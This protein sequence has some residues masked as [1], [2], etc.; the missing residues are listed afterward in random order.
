V[1]TLNRDWDALKLT[2]FDDPKLQKKEV[3]DFTQYPPRSAGSTESARRVSPVC[4]KLPSP[5]HSHGGPCTVQC[6]SQPWSKPL[7][8]P[9]T[10]RRE[11]MVS[12]RL[13][14]PIKPTGFLATAGTPAATKARATRS[15]S[16]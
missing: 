12:Y 2:K 13:G 10:K 1:K 14:V 16:T 5:P 7:S 4:D 6:S 3:S 8:L 9:K 15:L 11:T